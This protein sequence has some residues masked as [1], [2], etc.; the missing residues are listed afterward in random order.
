MQGGI[1]AYDESRSLQRKE[2]MA[3]LKAKEDA[4]PRGALHAH[5]GAKA[6]PVSHVA[7]SA[8]TPGELAG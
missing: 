4:L 1:P 3:E 6:A 5:G 8:S 7:R 2:M